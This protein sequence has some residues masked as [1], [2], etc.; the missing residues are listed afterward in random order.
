VDFA[1]TIDFHDT[2]FQ[3][4]EWFDLEVRELPAKFFAWLSVHADY[5]TSPVAVEDVIPLYREIRHNAIEGGIEVDSLECVARICRQIDLKVDP[6][7]IEQGVDALMRGVLDSSGPAPGAREL[8]VDL[9]GK[10]I[11]LGVISNAIHHP[12]LEWALDRFGMLHCFDLILSSARAGYYKS[13]VELYQLALTSLGVPPER[14]IHIGDSYRFDVLGAANAGMRTV[15][16]NPAGVEPNGHAPD[17]VIES[18]EGLAPQ[19]FKLLDLDSSAQS[20]PA[21]AR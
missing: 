10:G 1:V 5:P 7:I 16:L 15:W 20:G 6:A 12:F 17:L 13:R 4:D 14:T 18:L 19:L 21:N 8:V 11:K 3:C 2:L 9:H